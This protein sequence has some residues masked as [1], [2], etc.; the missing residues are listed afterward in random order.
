MDGGGIYFP[1]DLGWQVTTHD[2]KRTGLL[3]AACEMGHG[4]LASLLIEKY[5]M[6]TGEV[7]RRGLTPL[8]RAALRNQ[9]CA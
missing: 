8:A 2:K 9:V 5:K 6:S 3:H 7:D 1:P 4:Q